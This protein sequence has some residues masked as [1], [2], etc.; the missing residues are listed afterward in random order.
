MESNF[1]RHRHQHYDWRKDKKSKKFY[2][3]DF[4]A[5][6]WRRCFKCK[7]PWF[8][9][10]HKTHGKIAT[11][12]AVKPTPRFGGLFFEDNI[13]EKFTEKPQEG[14]GWINGGF[15]VFEPDF[16]DYIEDDSTILEREPLEKLAGK[17]QLIAFKH[18]G[19]WQCMDTLREKNYLN[20]LWDN[21][22]APWKV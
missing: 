22:K 2:K 11:L 13:V 15:F 6:I 4:H 14:E 12:T 16:L 18:Q 10:F 17:R 3:R 20:E 19:F 21:D 1:N 9:K 8:I 5:H 7:Y